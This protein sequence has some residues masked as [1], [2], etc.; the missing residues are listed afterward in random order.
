MEFIAKQTVELEQLRKQITVNSLSITEDKIDGNK[1]AQEAELLE[2]KA[3][4]EDVLST[5]KDN[6]ALIEEM[7]KGNSVKN[8]AEEKDHS[9]RN[10]QEDDMHNNNNNLDQL[11]QLLEEREK[12]LEEKDSQIEEMKMQWE[13]ERAELVKPALQQV[14]SQLEELRET[15]SIMKYNRY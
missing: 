8:K 11:Q 4:Y 1:D 12:L 10:S 13:I 14:N 9:S 3:R 7:R 6:E 5:L 2:L 15:V